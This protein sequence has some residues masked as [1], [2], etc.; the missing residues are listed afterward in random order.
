MYSVVQVKWNSFFQNFVFIYSYV[1]IQHYILGSAAF[2][3]GCWLFLATFLNTLPIL[4]QLSHIQ[5]LSFNVAG[6]SDKPLYILSE[7]WYLRYNRLNSMSWTHIVSSPQFTGEIGIIRT[8]KYIWG[9]NHVILII[10]G[11]VVSWIR[12]SSSGH[13]SSGHSPDG[14]INRRRPS[15]CIYRSIYTGEFKLCV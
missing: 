15:T 5:T 3:V 12:R 4:Q 10:I 14:E 8:N 7:C 6:I 13:C 9:V 1:C 2:V 11:H